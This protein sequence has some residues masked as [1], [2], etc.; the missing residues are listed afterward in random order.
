MK[1]TPPDA[2]F[3]LLWA[4]VGAARE[5]LAWQYDPTCPICDTWEGGRHKPD[6]VYGL[7]EDALNDVDN[8]AIV[9]RTDDP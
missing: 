7:L 6:C 4:V 1:H 3:T 8:A 5:V 9:I 2:P